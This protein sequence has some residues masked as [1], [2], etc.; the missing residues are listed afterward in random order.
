MAA[1]STSSSSIIQASIINQHDVNM[2]SNDDDAGNLHKRRRF[3]SNSSTSFVVEEISQESEDQIWLQSPEIKK[4]LRESSLK[5]RALIKSQEHAR[6]V[7]EGLNQHKR[8]QTVPNSIKIKNKV[9][10]PENTSD[11]IKSAIHASFLKCSL[12]I[13]DQIILARTNELTQIGKDIESFFEKQEAEISQNLT[14]PKYKDEVQ[15]KKLFPEISVTSPARIRLFMST[16]RISC[17][18]IY[19]EHELKEAINE[20]KKIEQRISYM[21]IEEKVNNKPEQSMR[22]LVKTTVSLELNKRL[23]SN[24]SSKKKG[25]NDHSKGIQSNAKN[26]SNKKPSTSNVSSSSKSVKSKNAKK[27]TSQNKNRSASHKKMTPKSNSVKKAKESESRK[28]NSG[29]SMKKSSGNGV[30]NQSG[31]SKRL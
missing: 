4:N 23:N 6:S 27:P 21:E 18:K 8:D 20:K 16:L 29:Q 22:D 5:F 19:D 31:K 13:L 2:T 10:L 26:D 7:M 1:S 30:K 28:T 25:N 14:P 12:E 17:R 11:E 24:N 9:N 3:E 15:Y